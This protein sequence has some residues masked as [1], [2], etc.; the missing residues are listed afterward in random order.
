MSSSLGLGRGTGTTNFLSYARLEL[1]LLENIR[2]G[3][4]EWNSIIGSTMSNNLIVG[5]TTQDESRG[6]T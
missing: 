2:S 1:L 6:A 4:G 5:Y 3:I